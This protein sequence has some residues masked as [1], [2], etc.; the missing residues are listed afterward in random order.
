MFGA[1]A[2]RAGIEVQRKAENFIL[3]VVEVELVLS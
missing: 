2:T 3:E 1:N